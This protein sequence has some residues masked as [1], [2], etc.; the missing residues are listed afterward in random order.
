MESLRSYSPTLS[1]IHYTAPDGTVQYAQGPTTVQ[2][3]QPGVID[4]A[5]STM[6]GMAGDAMHYGAAVADAAGA[7]QVGA[8]LR[9]QGS[10]LGARA[11]A[12]VQGLPTRVEDAIET[13]D[14][15]GYGKNLAGQTLGSVVPTMLASAAGNVLLS[16]VPGLRNSSF[17]RSAI[18]GAAF[19]FPSMAGGTAKDLYENEEA[20]AN[21]TARQ[22]L[23]AATGSGAAQA[24][25]ESIPEALGVSKIGK[26]FQGAIKAPQSAITAV[27]KNTLGEAATE[28][29]QSAVN[30]NVVA[31]YAPDS[32]SASLRNAEAFSDY[33]NSAIGGAAGGAGIG[34]I[35]HAGT[36][37]GQAA[38]GVANTPEYLTEAGGWAMDSAKGFA[39]GGAEKAKAAFDGAFPL[40]DD[41][42]GQPTMY[43]NL[44]AAAQKGNEYASNLWERMTASAEGA[45]QGVKASDPVVKMGSAIRG[46]VTDILGD[47]SAP[48]SEDERAARVQ[49][50]QQAVQEF[51]N[52]TGHTVEDAYSLIKAAGQGTLDAY[53][54]SKLGGEISR[55]KGVAEDLYK[56]GMDWGTVAVKNPQAAH[57]ALYDAT[58]KA[59]DLSGTALIKGNKFLT[60]TYNAIDAN[61]KDPR[62]RKAFQALRVNALLAQ[63]AVAAYVRKATDAEARTK[64]LDALRSDYG[65]AVDEVWGAMQNAG[66]SAVDAAHQWVSDRIKDTVDAARSYNE[67]RAA[68]KAGK[69]APSEDAVM[70]AL[71]GAAGVPQKAYNPAADLSAVAD[72]HAGEQP[73][74]PAARQEAL[75]A[76]YEVLTGRKGE[77]RIIVPGSA[78][79][80]ANA[81]MRSTPA[82]TLRNKIQN[83]PF[84]KRL[85]VDAQ[86]V[87][88]KAV[89]K[90]LSGELTPEQYSA[91]VEALTRVFGKDTSAMLRLLHDA[92]VDAEGLRNEVNSQLSAGAQYDTLERGAAP[93]RD[94]G[95]S[96]GSEQT[97][98]E[99]GDNLTVGD[100]VEGP[101]PVHAHPL[102]TNDPRLIA[103]RDAARR[104]EE[105]DK[106]RGNQ[107]R[108][109][110][111][112]ASEYLNDYVPEANHKDKRDEFFRAVISDRAEALRDTP[113]GIG[114]SPE[115][116]RAEAR[117]SV[118][119]EVKEYGEDKFW[120]KHKLLMKDDS[121]RIDGALSEYDWEYLRP[122]GESRDSSNM[123]AIMHDGTKRS[124]NP[125][126]LTTLGFR[127]MHGT[128]YVKD[129]HG[130]ARA[131]AE[132]LST[133]INDD[134]VETLTDA[135]RNAIT[136]KDDAINIDS[137]TVVYNLRTKG[138]VRPVRYGE[139]KWMSA[140]A[141]SKAAEHDGVRRG[142]TA[143]DTEEMT[144]KAAHKE[145]QKIRDS[146]RYNVPAEGVQDLRAQFD[147]EYAKGDE[148]DT[149]KLDTLTERIHREQTQPADTRVE[150]E[151]SRPSDAPAI[152]S[153]GEDGYNVRTAEAD[154]GAKVGTTPAARRGLAHKGAY[155]LSDTPRTGLAPAQ[156]KFL[157]EL[158]GDATDT[159]RLDKSGMSRALAAKLTEDPNVLTTTE[160]EQEAVDAASKR[161]NAAPTVV[162]FVRDF[163][164]V[165]DDVHKRDVVD[166]LRALEEQGNVG[167]SKSLAIMTALAKARVELDVRLKPEIKPSATAEAFNKDTAQRIIDT[168][169]SSEAFSKWFD[170]T[171]PEQRRAATQLVREQVANRLARGLPLGSRLAALRKIVTEAGD[172]MPK[173]A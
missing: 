170:D 72:K 21:T 92:S 64:A 56:K 34:G 110:T 52:T 31:N 19:N 25:L 125:M 65:P 81:S 37:I 159:T 22:R 144:T 67:E 171:T 13:G 90:A 12:L 30:R 80:G 47:L 82:N 130:V 113:D 166:G 76:F 120:D 66:G 48:M 16:R 73:A 98:D 54:D 46:Q 132:G 93:T 7:E 5:Y 131:F 127:R 88:A 153:V 49:K 157:R 160:V 96:T 89:D 141:T 6:T 69:S 155:D 149:D 4:S 165:K 158:I 124:V 135:K 26:A 161:L 143:A 172:N 58:K 142:V 146:R 36:R 60:D 59:F 78:T 169:K 42:T 150:G 111:I 145:N 128:D 152:R 53:N 94:A 168:T 91:F 156:R 84:I 45:V 83:N 14:Y 8:S 139:L 35:S 134:N 27:A 38:N 40:T 151:G 50:A 147:E 57:D 9:R 2:A 129:M 32:Y 162:A 95:D 74:D 11:Q 114:L 138:G 100:A 167:A 119:A 75:E 79:G 17:L 20:R 86:P 43:G 163:L 136:V 55:M 28:V 39:L 108:H 109:F 121:Q 77:Q 87:V 33:L 115:E 51:A 148:A 104:D 102:R 97:V 44:Y 71:L 137:E 15:A 140:H 70:D 173:K 164:N 10:K 123:T 118:V 61:A 107:P 116:L 1:D 62:T 29:G 23:L 154:T 101:V 103:L 106:L 133:V 63:K 85:P 18:G 99:Y 105:A 24:A 41:A 68:A 3:Q 112:S 126:A 122:R 117:K